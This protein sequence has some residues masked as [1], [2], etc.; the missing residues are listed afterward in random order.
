MASP[1]K[2]LG[3]DRQQVLV[4]NGSSYHCIHPCRLQ[5]INNH[6]QPNNL[7]QLNEHNNTYPFNNQS[8]SVGNEQQSYDTDSELPG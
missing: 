4:K 7:S 6:P 1:A 5:L 2:V 8:I 3:Q